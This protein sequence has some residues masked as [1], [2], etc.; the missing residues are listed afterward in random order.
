MKKLAVLLFAFMLAVT[1]SS[2]ASDLN[3]IFRQSE[4]YVGKDAYA[5]LYVNLADMYS[6]TTYT[7]KIISGNLPPGCHLE[8]NRRWRALVRGRPAEAGTYNFTV[9]V[10]SS[11]G[12][13]GTVT[14]KMTVKPVK[15]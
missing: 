7:F 2:A 9:S 4:C 13:S 3:V 6:F 5:E 1:E 11:K 10:A 12:E 15:R 14:C 8:Q